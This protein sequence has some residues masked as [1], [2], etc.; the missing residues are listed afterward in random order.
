[1]SYDISIQLKE[2]KSRDS[3]KQ[4]IST[5]PN[6]EQSCFVIE[7]S[8]HM[9]I[10]FEPTENN[11][12]LITE[13]SFHIPYSFLNKVGVDFDLYFECIN[14]IA[15]KVNSVAYDKQL[16]IYLNHKDFYLSKPKLI[17]T[18]VQISR[19]TYENP[20]LNIHCAYKEMVFA[21]DLANGS[22][23]G[24]QTTEKAISNYDCHVKEAGNEKFKAIS[25][26]KQKEIT[27]IKTQNPNEPF[28]IKR[29]GETTHLKIVG[30]NLLMSASNNKVIK[31][32]EITKLKNLKTFKG[33]LDN[34]SDFLLI[35]PKIM[36]SSS[37]GGSLIF[38]DFE[39][40]E[41]L[42][43]I[44]HSNYNFSWLAIDAKG[45]FD[46]SENYKGIMRWDFG[47]QQYTPFKGLGIDTQGGWNYKPVANTNG[48]HVKG[49]VTKILSITSENLKT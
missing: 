5:I 39:T 1:M 47:K 23:L 24:F 9:E 37:I 15:D 6:I 31:L 45:N 16:D 3:L 19:L 10:D 42:L 44:L 2:P 17:Q 28:V 30:E 18:A 7:D 12:E 41:I 48:V 4:I 8:H 33:H 40:A 14:K 38:W 32:W 21:W 34:I 46:T 36:V 27:I 49:L 13:L 25:N 20:I 26:F 22:F 35:S 29:T 11:S 43:T